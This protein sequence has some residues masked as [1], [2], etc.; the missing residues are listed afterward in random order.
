MSYLLLYDHYED[1]SKMATQYINLSA[2][3]QWALSS[4]DMCGHCG[5]N[6]DSTGCRARDCSACSQRWLA[7]TGNDN[8]EGRPVKETCPG[9]CAEGYGTAPETI[10]YLEQEGKRIAE[11]LASEYAAK[12]KTEADRIIAN[13]E[14]RLR[15]ID[16]RNGVVAV[17]TKEA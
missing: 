14:A 7:A 9:C 4:Y 2:R 11:E 16:E 10:A 15:E 5:L 8:G 17:D 1:L 6:H 13:H 12:F 3:D